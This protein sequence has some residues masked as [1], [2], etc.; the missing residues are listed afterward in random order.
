MFTPKSTAQVMAWS[1][2]G[3][4]TQVVFEGTPLAGIPKAAYRLCWAHDPDLA[5]PTVFTLELADAGALVGPTNADED[6]T[7]AFFCTLGLACA[8]T[9]SGHALTGN[10][11]VGIFAGAGCAGTLASWAGSAV[12]VRGTLVGDTAVFAFGTPTSGVAGNAYRVCWAYEPVSL[13]TVNFRVVV[14]G[15]GSLEGPS[16]ISEVAVV[17]LSPLQKYITF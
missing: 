5:D 15:T 13:A 9:L 8:L 3:G 6:A 12:A 10:D 17:L 1:A 4:G 2:S 11:A 7:N 14:D 16:P